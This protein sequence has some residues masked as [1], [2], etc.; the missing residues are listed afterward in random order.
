M[1]PAIERFSGSAGAS[2]LSPG[3]RFEIDITPF[4]IPARAG[5]IRRDRQPR[6][7]V[8]G[9]LTPARNDDASYDSSHVDGAL[10]QFLAEGAL[11]E[12]GHERRARARRTC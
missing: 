8:P 6:P 11:V 5:T 4:V 10:R 1:Q 2:F 9:R 12:L 7:E 3:L